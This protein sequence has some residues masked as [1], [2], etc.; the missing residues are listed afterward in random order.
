[1]AQPETALRASVR[2]VE[3]IPAVLCGGLFHP[4]P[5]P[6]GEGEPFS[7]RSTIQ[8]FR[9][10]L[11][12]CALFPLPEGEGQGEGKRRLSG[13]VAPRSQ[14]RF[15]GILPRR[16]SPEPKIEATNVVV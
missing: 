9:P 7:T 4:S 6:R 11:R 5:L 14:P 13:F 8:T 10:S 1:M 15:G 12:G 3:D 2:H 16:A